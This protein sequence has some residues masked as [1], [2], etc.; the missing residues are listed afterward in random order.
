MSM[1]HFQMWMIM[2]FPMKINLLLKVKVSFNDGFARLN[3][4]NI[5]KNG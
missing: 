3:L 2:G 4:V 5:Y 1:S